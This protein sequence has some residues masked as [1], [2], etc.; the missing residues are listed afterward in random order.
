MA[1]NCADALGIQPVLQPVT[2]HTT[3]SDL[4]SYMAANGEF[5]ASP[6]YEAFSKGEIFIAD[7]FDAASPAI[8]VT[9]NAVVASR[10]PTF[11]NL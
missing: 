3:K 7:E 8:A 1:L 4:L 9:L 11:P 5:V 6:F 10:T 2:P